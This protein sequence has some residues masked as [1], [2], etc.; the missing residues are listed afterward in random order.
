MTRDTCPARARTCAGV[1]LH[2][3]ALAAVLGAEVVGA[4]AEGRRHRAPQHGQR[5]PLVGDIPGVHAGVPL[6]HDMTCYMTTSHVTRTGH[7]TET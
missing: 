1:V 5:P 2:L 3:H 6:Q 7:V 4:L